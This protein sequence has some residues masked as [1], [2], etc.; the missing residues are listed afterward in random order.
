MTEQYTKGTIYHLLL[1]IQSFNGRF[2]KDSFFIYYLLRRS[3]FTH[4]L[5]SVKCL[6]FCL[7]FFFSD[8]LTENFSL[9]ICVF[10]EGVT[11]QSLFKLLVRKIERRQ[12]S[13]PYC[14]T[15]RR[16]TLQEVKDGL[17]VYEK[18]HHN[19]SQFT[20]ITIYNV[21]CKCIDLHTL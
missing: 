20:Y 13:A 15:S 10:S 12:R 6:C 19:A 1:S 9:C 8:F 16:K 3:R 18:E 11:L 4:G 2:S 7:F 5:C 17:Y 21:Q 14:I